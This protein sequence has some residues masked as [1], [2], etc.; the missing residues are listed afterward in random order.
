MARTLD[1]YAAKRFKSAFL[2]KNLELVPN[3]HKRSA[4][5]HIE[6][7]CDSSKRGDIVVFKQGVYSYNGVCFRLRNDDISTM[8]DSLARQGGTLDDVQPVGK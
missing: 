1:E 2:S 8:L 6:L 4:D 3:S 7:L 5:A